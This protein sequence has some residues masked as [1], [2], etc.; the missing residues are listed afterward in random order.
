M[1]FRVDWAAQRAYVPHPPKMLQVAQGEG[2]ITRAATGCG[3]AHF[4]VSKKYPRFSD[5]GSTNP[6]VAAISIEGQVNG[7]RRDWC[8]PGNHKTD[9]KM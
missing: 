3:N 4:Y 9:M 1:L 5:A 8:R 2:L 6:I 7:T